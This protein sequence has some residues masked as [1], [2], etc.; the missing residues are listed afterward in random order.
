[1]NSPPHHL[2]DPAG[3]CAAVAFAFLALV[4]LRLGIPSKPYFDEIHYLP[5]ARALLAG[6]DWLNREH[7]MFGKVIIAAGIGLFG[8]HPW[9]WRLPSALAGTLTVWA[10]MRALWF[11]SLSRFATL[12]YGVLLTS[13]FILFVHARI[14]MLDVFM[15]ALVTVV[16]WQCAAA[17]REPE[18]G[19][20]SLAI[21]GVALGLAL[22]TK[23]NAIPLAP[24]PGLAF[25]AARLHACGWRGLIGRRGP[26][27]PG[28]RLGEAA[29]W[30]GIVPLAV[31]ALTYLP[32]F[33]VDPA[34]AGRRGLIG[35]HQMM[36]SMQ[37]SVVKPHPYQ[38]V[39][40]DWIIN[41][42]AIWYLYEPV[43]G[44]QRGVLLIGNPLTMLLG[45]P[46][47]AWCAWAGFARKRADALAA[48]LVFAASLA[49]W[50]VA[51][52]PIQFYYHYFLPSMALLAAL[53]LALDALRSRGWGWL[54]WL[55]LAGSVG[56]FAWFFPILD[57]SPLQGQ[58]AF[59]HWM[60][61]DSWR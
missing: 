27:V 44:A 45:L 26:P 39:W 49:M 41:R 53:A 29:I 12:A 33:L 38:S 28:I 25:L 55:V 18:H 17:V 24:L 10:A 31:Y 37:E 36:L 56:V 15:V 57:A 42:R 59:E 32:A 20:R 7:P 6:T 48:F 19:R 2:R 13:G 1:M 8:D 50:I 60:W 43:D 4:C 14:A 52:K 58:R 21:A 40:T 30:L 61:V 22:G 3:W 16:F 35:I 23:W 54:S 9:A 47:L 46:A 11:A 5:A 34:E 51:A